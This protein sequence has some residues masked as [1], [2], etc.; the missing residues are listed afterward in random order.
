MG[1]VGVRGWGVGVGEEKV[2]GKRR[3]RKGEERKERGS[4]IQFKPTNEG[5]D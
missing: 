3:G 5:V 2:R 4:G 1:V